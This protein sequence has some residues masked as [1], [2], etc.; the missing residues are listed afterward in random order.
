MK[1]ALLF[2]LIIAVV[3]FVGVFI[4]AKL[5]TNTPQ[6]KADGIDLTSSTL[7]EKG[8]YI[9][10]T[11]DCTSCHTRE[12]N[13]TFAGSYPLVSPI[14]AMYSSNITP[15]KET[16]IGNYTLDEFSRAVRHG[17][18]ADGVTLYPAMPY[19]SFAMIT[20]EDM[21]ALYAYFMHGVEPVRQA[22]KAP[23]ITWPLSIRWPVAIW[24][25]ALTPM[26]EPIQTEDYT[27]PKIARGAYLVQGLGHCG[28]CHTPRN[29]F[30]AEVAL[31]EKSNQYL[32]GGQIIDGWHTISLRGG[33]DGLG[34]WSEA[35]II[36][37]LKTGRNLRTVVVGEG[38]NDVVRFS[39]SH[40]TDDDLAA[41]AAYLK[42]LSATT[43]N[44]VSYT[45]QSAD[46]VVELTVQ[47]TNSY[48]LYR[49]N[50]SG[51][52]GLQGQGGVGLPVLAGNPSVLAE[53]PITVI[54][55][56][57]SGFDV[58]DM[59]P[60]ALPMEMPGFGGELSDDEIATIATWI[61]SSWG[62]KAPHVTIADVQRVKTEISH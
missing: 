27:N 16:G 37:T 60:H 59:D 8:K 13:P 53:D 10:I 9:A 46:Q 5:P 19:P 51:C 26:A 44:T 24:R 43:P 35:D 41:I 61:R 33:A 17:I 20:D 54:H 48:N 40:M 36:S 49:V 58:P 42:T 31:S 18:R 45:P 15:D 4:F 11:G 57:I 14:G 23:D 39:T 12:R 7:I 62:N 47:Q 30:M 52:H 6:L 34:F 29:T 32:S 38:M 22:N 50:C 1:R 55:L 2:I 21:T 28:A 25:K 3:V 56:I